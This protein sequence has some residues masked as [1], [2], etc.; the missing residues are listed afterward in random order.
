MLKNRLYQSYFLALCLSF[1]GL[2][3][4]AETTS[5][6]AFT[7]PQVT[8]NIRDSNWDAEGIRHD[9]EVGDVDLAVALDQ[10]QYPSLEPLI[11]QF[12]DKRGVRIAVSDGTCGISAG[13]LRRKAVDVGGFCC[14][15]GRTDR[16][17]GLQFHTL[18]I[19]ALALITHSENSV[20][21]V[22]IEEARNI[23]RG[24]LQRWSELPRISGNPRSISPVVRPHCR[25]RPG[26]WRLLLPS[27][28]DFS[29]SMLKIGA[30]PDMIR[31]TADDPG[32]IGYET[33]WMV[34]KYDKQKRLKI[35]AINGI[36]PKNREALAEGRYPL[37]RTFNLTTWEGAAA[38]PLAQEL[39]DWLIKK[40]ETLDKVHGMI[41][42]KML[43]A[44]GWH[45]KGNELT[46]EPGT[47]TADADDIGLRL[48]A[49]DV[50]RA[51]EVFTLSLKVSCW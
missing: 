28:K 34:Q 41:S 21:N 46:G 11:R 43:R 20:K 5:L 47:V 50:R 18:G 48:S 51:D 44:Q 38:K 32:A 45:F 9:K 6:P 16:L 31:Y 29:S 27:D 12:A 8:F 40:V 15:P 25:N 30:I 17:P 19:A 35:L 36:N 42:A 3:P 23:F 49:F 37:Y 13:L 33:L 14:P 26:H 2:I 24:D 7:N 39:I 4:A 10:Q 22:S 1:S